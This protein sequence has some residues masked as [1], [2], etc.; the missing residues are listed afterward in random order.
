MTADELQRA[1]VEIFGPRGW[2]SDLA[3]HL[4]IDRTTIYRY[5][6]GQLPV[7]GPVEAAVSCW[8]VVFRESG[9]RPDVLLSASKI[10][11]AAGAPAA[12]LNFERTA[13]GRAVAAGFEDPGA[14][15]SAP[16]G[17]AN[18]VDRRR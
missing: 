14:K 12:G 7:P 4:K 17:P 1:A 8:L 5:V 3:A 6:Q 16:D 2:T 18:A 13:Q 11:P 10:S 9:R 15:P